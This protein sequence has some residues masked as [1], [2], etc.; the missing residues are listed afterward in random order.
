MIARLVVA[1]A[2]AAVVGGL[3][4]SDKAVRVEL[5]PLAPLVLQRLAAQDQPTC[6]AVATISAAP[7]TAFAC[8]RDAGP[9]RLDENAIFEIGSITRVFTGL[10]LADMVRRGEVALS[11][12]ASKYAP[13]GAEPVERGEREITLESLVTHSSD[14][15]PLPPDLQLAE[16]LGRAAGMPYDRLLEERV[17]APLA[18][19]STTVHAEGMRSSLADL[20]RFAQAAA[21]RLETPLAPSFALSYAPLRGLPGDAMM[22]CGWIRRD[23]RVGRVLFHDGPA[24][25]FRAAL[26][27]NPDARTAAVV[28]ANS[29]TNIDD[30]AL[31]LVDPTQPLKR[32]RAAIAGGTKKP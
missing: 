21:G 24:S 13:P 25:G 28:L 23:R 11:D 8:T 31:H 15:P 20:A 18:M 19:K 26:A 4:A 30:L 14:L 5:D 9:A 27:V 2:L 1:V 3:T 32:K 7:R 12:P 6:V 22:A 16:L 17:L 29:S 10:L